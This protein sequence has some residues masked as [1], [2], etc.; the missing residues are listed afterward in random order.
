MHR[1]GHIGIGHLLYSPMAFVLALYEAWTLLALGLVGI[2]FFSYA[3]DFDLQM[4]LVD[5]R[6]ITHTYLAAGVAGLL[7]MLV[8]GWLAAEGVAT[9][10]GLSPLVSTLVVAAFGFLVGAL[11]VLSHLLGDV[12]TP[13]GINP[14]QPFGGETVSLELVYASNRWANGA[15]SLAG[16]VALVAAVVGGVLV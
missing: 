2:T 13:M 1:E 12:L 9:I 15:L 16:G 11:G 7:S 14:W 6:G 10:G 8:A 4:P 3:P 5:H